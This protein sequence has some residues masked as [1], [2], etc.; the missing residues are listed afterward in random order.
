AAQFHDA[1][2]DMARQHAEVNL[3][4]AIDRIWDRYV[5]INNEEKREEFRCV[6]YRAQYLKGEA[7]VEITFSDA[8]KPSLIHLKGP[9]TRVELN[10]DSHHSSPL[11]DRIYTRLPHVPT[12]GDRPITLHRLR[13]LLHLSAAYD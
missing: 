3:M 9:V 5:I 7:N 12:I 2:P 8:V 6:Q 11:S 1:F 4:D 10:H 13:P